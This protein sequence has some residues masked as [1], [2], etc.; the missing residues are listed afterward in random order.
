MTSS[1]YWVVMAKRNLHFWFTCVFVSF[2]IQPKEYWRGWGVVGS[3]NLFTRLEEIRFFS[4]PVSTMASIISCF[5]WILNV[6]KSSFSSSY[7]VDGLICG[8]AMSVRLSSASST[9]PISTTSLAMADVVK[10]FPRS[11][12]IHIF[13]NNYGCALQHFSLSVSSDLT[14]VTKFICVCKLKCV[15][16][17]SLKSL[18]GWML[19][20]PSLFVP[21]SNFRLPVFYLFFWYATCIEDICCHMQP[22]FILN[23]LR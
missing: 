20:V 13:G 16:P 1:T 17:M 9:N 4:L 19:L 7:V 12:F 22:H 21:S 15:V 3:P 8:W 18:F 14:M 5:N 11:S 2:W 6:N 23:L 10:R